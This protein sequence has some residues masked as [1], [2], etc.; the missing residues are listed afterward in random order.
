MPQ[1]SLEN[2]A[3]VAEDLRRAIE[4]ESFVGDESQDFRVTLSAGVVS[5]MDEVVT[6]R[7]LLSICDRSLYRAKRKG[8]N[9]V[10]VH[11]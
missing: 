6:V 3:Q 5:C 11:Q 10:M 8:R 2:A 7:D 1:T 4:N 9:R